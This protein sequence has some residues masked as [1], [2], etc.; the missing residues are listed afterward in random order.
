MDEILYCC[1]FPDFSENAETVPELLSAMDYEFS[2]WRDAETGKRTHTLYF[3]TAEE[4]ADAGARI[5]S[6]RDVWRGMEVEIGDPVLADLKNCLQRVC[7]FAQLRAFFT[8]Q[9]Q[10]L[11]VF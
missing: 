10:A 1:S 6:L 2:S 4:A 9:I 5:R 3:K 7:V 11:S 8:C